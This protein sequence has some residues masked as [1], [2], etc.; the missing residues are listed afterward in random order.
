MAEAKIRVLIADD[1][2][3]VR[4]AIRNAFER[5]SDM[6][7]LAEAEDGEAAVKLAGELKPDVMIMD[8]IM[9]KLTGIQ[10]TREIRKVSPGTAVLILTSYDDDRY[11]IGLLESG[12]AGYLLKSARGQ[13]LV[14]AVRAV[15]AGESVLHPTIIAKI[16]RYSMHMADE[17]DRHEAKDRLSTRELEVLKLTAKGMS[18][19]DIAE[20]LI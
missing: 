10:A 6:S 19:K 20:K 18:N 7:I 3:L 17:V 13:D 1:H 8:I 16:L 4:E 15:H 11:I 5:H 2:P 14:N 9:P 12:A